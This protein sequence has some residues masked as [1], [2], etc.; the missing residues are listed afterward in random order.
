MKQGLPE[1]FH[2]LVMNDYGADLA[3]RIE[4]SCTIQRKTTLRANRLHSDPDEVAAILDREKIDW[5]PVPWYS[6]AFVLSHANST[7]LAP[8]PLYT[9]G[10]IYVQSLSSMLPPLIL[11]PQAGQDI[12]DMCAAPGGKTTQI[13]ALTDGKA[14][15]TACEMHEP[16]AQKLDFTLR[17]Q[18]VRNATVMRTDA[19]TLDDFFSFD[20]VLVDAPCSG[21][22]TLLL[23]HPKELDR[24]TDHLLQKSKR[25]QRALL[26]KGLSLMRPGGT[27]V[28]STCSIL[29]QEN[30]EIVEAAL[31]KANR[32][33]SYELAAISLS[34]QDEIPQLPT[35]LEGTICVCPDELYEGFFVAQIKRVK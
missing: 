19:R 14:Y 17:R 16:R 1:L 28:Y 2:T 12:C 7:M 35:T 33:G 23:S 30:E 10:M 20:R 4:S 27:L 11:Q 9:E 25:S 24:F 21:S 29:K 8:L 5:E 18:G 22:G 34:H 31:D 15:I 13:A 32:K 6:D 26:E 3:A